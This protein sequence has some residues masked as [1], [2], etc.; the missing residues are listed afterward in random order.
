MLSRDA[1]HL[2]DGLRFRLRMILVSALAAIA[3]VEGNAAHDR[4]RIDRKSEPVFGALAGRR[5][6]SATNFIVE[7]CGRGLAMLSLMGVGGN[8]IPSYSNQC[9]RPRQKW[10]GESRSRI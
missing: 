8:D 10:E 6:D 2:G 4:N 1:T 3:R 9:R 7:S 5:F